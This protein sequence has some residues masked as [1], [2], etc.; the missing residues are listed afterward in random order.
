[1]NAPNFPVLTPAE[2]EWRRILTGEG[3]HLPFNAHGRDLI[4][5]FADPSL[6]AGIPPHA[7]ALEIAGESALLEFQFSPEGCF[8]SA[9][10][11]GIPDH[12]ETLRSAVLAFLGKELIDLLAVRMNLPVSVSTRTTSAAA[13]TATFSF[14][15]NPFDEGSTEAWGLLSL[16]TK[17]ATA[18]VSSAVAWPRY[19]GALADTVT[20]DCPVVIT[21]LPLSPRDLRDLVPGDMILLG[22]AADLSPVL[23]LPGGGTLPCSVTGLEVPGEAAA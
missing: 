3:R 11:G 18:L 23:S 14:R 4:L 10:P 19:K 9:V 7:L 21:S 8:P 6:R 17:A 12:P 5:S 16:G 20:V 13:P 2:A 22:T 15:I 1:M